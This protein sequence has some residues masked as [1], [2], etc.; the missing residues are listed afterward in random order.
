MRGIRSEVR[1]LGVALVI[2]VD[3]AVATVILHVVGIELRT[4]LLAPLIAP[5]ALSA[6]SADEEE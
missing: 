5:C 3:R 2:M 6:C 1:S 4:R